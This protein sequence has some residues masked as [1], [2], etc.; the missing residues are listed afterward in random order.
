MTAFGWACVGAA[1]LI[2]VQT[3]SV[4]VLVVIMRRTQRNDTEARR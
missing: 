1:T 4:V 2:A 3:A